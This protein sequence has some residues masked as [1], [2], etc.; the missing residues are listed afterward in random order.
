MLRAGGKKFPSGFFP[1]PPPPPPRSPLLPQET[2]LR[3]PRWGLESL[4]SNQR[5]GLSLPIGRATGEPAAILPTSLPPP[6]PP[7]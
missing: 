4:D 1:L 3:A 2:V 7:S 6:P 5:P